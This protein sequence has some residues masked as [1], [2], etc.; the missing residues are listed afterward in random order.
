MTDVFTFK[1]K[2]GG[3]DIIYNGEVIPP[4]DI[5]D[6]LRDYYLSMEVLRE[7]VDLTFPD[8]EVPDPYM[9]RL[10]RKAKDAI[11]RWKDRT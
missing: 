2:S 10:Q 1:S 3:H 11:K 6:I 8:L 4:Q 7:I 5:C 9:A